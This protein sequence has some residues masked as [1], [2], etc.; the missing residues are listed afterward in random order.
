MILTKTTIVL[1]LLEGYKN[2]LHK[3]DL[4]GVSQ[5]RNSSNRECLHN[6][7]KRLKEQIEAHKVHRPQSTG[8]VSDLAPPIGYM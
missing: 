2:Y 7:P 8:P 4:I 6:T 3:K 5:F 1:V